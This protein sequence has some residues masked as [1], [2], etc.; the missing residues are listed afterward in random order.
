MDWI[1]TI[2]IILSIL[3]VVYFAWELSPWKM[4]PEDYK[5]KKK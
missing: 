5:K 2:I 1:L 4:F 3:P